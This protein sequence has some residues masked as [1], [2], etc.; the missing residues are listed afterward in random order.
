MDTCYKKFLLE[1]DNSM[2]DQ[3]IH[4]LIF[5]LAWKLENPEQILDQAVIIRLEALFKECAL[6]NDWMLHELHV[7]PDSVSMVI[8]LNPDIS[9]EAAVNRFKVGSSKIIKQEFNQLKN[10][11]WQKDFMAQ[12]IS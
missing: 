4:K 11:A 5:C 10:F 8:Q 3:I 2:G 1:S 9:I 6:I 12:T 7:Q